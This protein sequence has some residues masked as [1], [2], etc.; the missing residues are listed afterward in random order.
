MAFGSAEFLV[1]RRVIDGLVNLVG[2][3]PPAAGGVVRTLQTGMVQ[4]YALAMVLG[5]L[6]LLA[7]ADLADSD[8]G[9]EIEGP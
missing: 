6:V 7:V 9:I 3:I 4:F 8:C 2:K 1:D 5:V